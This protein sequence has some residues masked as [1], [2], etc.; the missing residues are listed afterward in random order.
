MKPRSLACALVALL[1]ACAP[2]TTAPRSP[3]PTPAQ[4][5]ALVARPCPE[6]RAIDRDAEVAG[7][8]VEVA[9]LRSSPPAGE[10]LRQHLAA[11][12]EV[13]QVAGAL[14]ESSLDVSG[15]WTTCREPGCEEGRMTLHLTKLPRRAD[16]VRLALSSEASSA[17]VEVDVADQ[18]PSLVRLPSGAE[19]VVTS[20]YLPAPKAASLQALYACK[21][22]QFGTNETV[23]AGTKPL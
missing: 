17:P 18:E 11:P 13:N 15:P 9:D 8:F 3:E 21:A 1:S 22:R 16:H 23:N 19:V 7:V 12:V 4:T 20:Y 2:K 6:L 14:V 5:S 10:P